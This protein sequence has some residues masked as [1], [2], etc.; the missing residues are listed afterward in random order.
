MNGASSLKPTGVFRAVTRCLLPLPWALAA[1]LAGAGLPP[2]PARAESAGE[3]GRGRLYAV[4]IGVEKYQR[5]SPLRYTVR[6]VEQL[7]ATLRQR[8]G[9]PEEN[10][11]QIVDGA[12]NPALQP[13]RSN[14]LAEL[15]QWL[16]GPLAE[17]QILVYFSGHG[18]QDAEGR[19]YL[20]PIDCDPKNPQDTGIAIQWLREQIAGCKAGLK[21]LIIDACHAGTEKGEEGLS[22]VTAKDLGEV[23]R[24][25]G[26]VVTIASSTAGE[27][28]QI[29]EAKQQSL[30]SYW[31]NQGL[32]GHADGDGDG[33]VTIDELYGYVHRRVTQTADA[34]FPRPQ[35]P[36]RIVRSGTLGVPAVL[37]LS[38]QTL[39]QVLADVGEQLAWAV[40]ERRLAKVGVLEFTNDTRLGELLGADFG[41]LGR[42]CAAKLEQQLVDLSADKYGVVNRRRLQSALE[43]EEFSLADVGSP[44][45]LRRLSE[46]AGGM[47]ALVL[48]TLRNR[49]GRTIHI[50][51]ELLRTDSEELA[52]SAG[53]AALLNESEWAMIG[54][55]VR[56]T[57]G[58]RRPV[59][60]DSP[61]AGRPET[62]R[63]IARLDERA[64]GPHPLLDPA[65]PYGVRIQVGG[66]ERKCVFRGN[67][68]FVAL[69]KGETY[70]VWIE[71]KSGQ[72]T[73]MRLLV[74]G[75]N[76]LP[77]K[78][79]DK[80][81]LTYAIAAP[82][83][84][85]EARPWLLD[86]EQSAVNAVRGFVTKTGVD[87]ELREFTIVDAADSLAARQRFTEQIGV[88][89]AAFY[90]PAKDARGIGTA[91]GRERAENLDERSGFEVGNLLGVVHIRY[92][93][94]G[95]LA[96]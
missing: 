65:F 35:T 46:T 34:F 86:P 44:E 49:T 73:L 23:F 57:P 50:H 29:W 38:P 54:R 82:V 18:F 79:L 25:L 6:D 87:G 89:T 72:P 41:L 48:G 1:I 2:C 77:E 17:D 26:G 5:A 94:P 74:D 11:L 3:L 39:N 59:L 52:G 20:A 70:E 27:K 80:G 36:V 95:A 12:S 30:F 14:L 37:R 92:V 90:A 45:A 33:E 85:D 43:D 10:I 8:G 88:I 32:K 67:D 71:N 51:C 28:S 75:L 15:P 47:Q 62:D 81:V 22:S 83:S 7:A 61:E 69:Q 91:A 53:G 68:C 93:E 60:P 58:D 42:C 24:D 31:L 9:V 56:V 64:K 16:A 63:V 13:L 96:D 78:L 4:L 55:S 66:K 84:L 19:L 76:T 21:T 40:E